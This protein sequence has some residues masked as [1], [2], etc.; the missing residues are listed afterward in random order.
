MNQVWDC[1]TCWLHYPLG[2]WPTGNICSSSTSLG[3]SCLV[4][5]VGHFFWSTVQ[6]CHLCA[7]CATTVSSYVCS[8]R[9]VYMFPLGYCMRLACYS[10]KL[11]GLSKLKLSLFLTR[12]FQ[13][14]N[15]K[16]ICSYVHIHTYS[17][18]MIFGLKCLLISHYLGKS[19]K[20]LIIV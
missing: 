4:Q 14:V 9:L 10:E 1:M 16:L 15:S 2:V 18:I 6:L 17:C 12:I 11:R 7:V 13:N 5:V 3:D 20:S 19:P 8:Y